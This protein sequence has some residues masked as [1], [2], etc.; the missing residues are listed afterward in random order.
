[1]YDCVY[2]YMRKVPSKN[3][4]NPAARVTVMLDSDNTKRLRE[5]QAK[6][7]TE[8]DKTISFSYIINQIVR[9][10][11]KNHKKRGQL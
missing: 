4:G 11:L 6:L 8:M 5:L 1:M 10:G 3:K 7:I 2:L 9:A